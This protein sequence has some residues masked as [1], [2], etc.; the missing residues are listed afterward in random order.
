MDKQL[1]LEERT[2][3]DHSK[4][5]QNFD[6]ILACYSQTDPDSLPALWQQLGQPLEQSERV[7][8][9]CILVQTHL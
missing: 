1:I 4:S 6:V 3:S 5:D 9:C 8:K 7:D 2:F